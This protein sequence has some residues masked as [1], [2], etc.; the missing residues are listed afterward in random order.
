MGESLLIQS[1]LFLLM[2]LADGDTR[3]EAIRAFVETPLC[4]AWGPGLTVGDVWEIAHLIE[5]GKA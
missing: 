3:E 1:R 5:G 2:R 4:R